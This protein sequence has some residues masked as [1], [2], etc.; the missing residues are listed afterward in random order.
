MEL[1]QNDI[2]F[3]AKIRDPLA[4]DDNVNHEY[5]IVDMVR[6]NYTQ[7]VNAMIKIGA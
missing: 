6:M 7:I 1:M 4:N 5:Y 2:E 3:L